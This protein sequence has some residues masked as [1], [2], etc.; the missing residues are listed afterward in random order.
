MY[1]PEI[2]ST[3]MR[4]EALRGS[5]LTEV[6]EMMGFKLSDVNNL[7]KPDVDTREPVDT[8]HK[9]I[10]GRLNKIEADKKVRAINSF[11]VFIVVDSLDSIDS[12]LKRRLRRRRPDTIEI[13]G[14][15]K[16]AIR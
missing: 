7:M 4:L 14:V 2:S 3:E 1:T 15:G 6:I 8:Y 13:T 9:I 16:L 12:D 5:G 11:D 10:S